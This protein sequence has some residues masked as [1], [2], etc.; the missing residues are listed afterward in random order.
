MEQI[1]RF[2][3]GSAGTLLHPL[4]A[5]ALLLAII[6]T[7]VLPRKYVIAPLLLAIFF[8]PKGQTLVLAGAHFTVARM[9]FLTCLVR[10]AWSK[11]ASPAASSKSIDR[12]F[13]LWAL[14][15]LIIFVLQWQD[16]QALIKS[17]GDLLDALGGYFVMR[18]LIQDREDVTRTIRVL[19]LIAMVSA[20]FMIDE[21][22]TGENLFARLGGMPPETLRDGKVRSQAAFEVFITAGTYGATLLP[23]LVWL[24]SETKSKCF[25]SWEYRCKRHGDHLSCQHDTFSL[26][27]RYPRALP[28]A[29]AQDNASAAM[30]ARIRPGGLTPGDERT[31]LVP[32]RKSRSDGFVIQLSPIY[33]DRQLYQAYRRLVVIGF[34]GLRQMGLRHVGFVG[35]ICV[36]C[37]ERRAAD[38]GAIYRNYLPLFWGPWIGEEA[39]EGERNEEWFIWCLGAALFAHVVAYFG[40]GY[41]DQMEFAWFALLAMICVAVSDTARATATQAAEDSLQ[42]NA[43]G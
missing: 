13:T 41:F 17:L 42:R 5:V 4:V 40:I 39:G 2:G 43:G 1:V 16:S 19:A 28:L 22:V 36:V 35:P 3:G 33:V 9:L 29:S 32:N 12:V 7:L 38:P 27:R 31:R 11:Q 23:L 10:R 14:S 30:G 15:S 6:L 26:C 24:W 25:A 20:G 37:R 18:Y 34:Q 21:Q 8:T